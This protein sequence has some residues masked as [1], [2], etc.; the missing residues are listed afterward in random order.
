MLEQLLVPF[1][2]PCCPAHGVLCA[3]VVIVFVLSW[4]NKDWLIEVTTCG[5]AKTCRNALLRVCFLV[6]TCFPRSSSACTK[7]LMPFLVGWPSP[8]TGNPWD[9]SCTFGAKYCFRVPSLSSSWFTSRSRKYCPCQWPHSR[10][11]SH[12]AVEYLMDRGYFAGVL[13]LSDFLT[14]KKCRDA[15]CCRIFFCSG[16]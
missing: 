6:P 2:K 1:F 8:Y 16:R 7:S 15:S 3:I 12:I 11:S 5:F 14:W 4:S 13:S 10:K 9:A